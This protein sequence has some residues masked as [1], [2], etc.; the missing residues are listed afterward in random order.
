MRKSINIAGIKFTRLTAIKF[1][2]YHKKPNGQRVEYWLCKCDCGKTSIVCKGDLTS[3]NIKSCG[4]LLKEALHTHKLSK[5]RLYKTYHNIKKRCYN[6]NNPRYKDYGKRGIKMC[7][8]WENDFVA[9]YNWSLNNGYKD[10]LTIDRI[11]NNGNYEPS[12]CRWVNA[13]IQGRNTRSNRLFTY[14][15]ETHCIVEWA[16]MYNIKYHTLKKRLNSYGWSI[17]KA[18][19]TPVKSIKNPRDFQRNRE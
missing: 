7:T 15:G 5:T 14:N 1:D 3:G 6:L 10:N 4:C 12:N 9:F 19:N 8:E 16:E 2:H 18:L 17:G 13:K 11:D